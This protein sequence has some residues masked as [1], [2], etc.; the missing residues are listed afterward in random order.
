[1]SGEYECYSVVTGWTP[2]EV[3]RIAAADELE[4]ASTRRDG[5]VRKSVTIW[6]VRAGDDLYVRSVYGRRSA[7]FR[8]V[9]EC[10]EGRIHAGGVDK[11]VRFVEVGATSRST[12]RSMAPTAR[13][14]SA[15]RTSTSTPP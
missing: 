10:H 8:G 6:V 5:S 11:D 13:S 4:L 9:Q 14:T 1:M 15:T 2:D 3:E 7:W 12:M